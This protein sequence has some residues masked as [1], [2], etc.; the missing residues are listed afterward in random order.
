M[1]TGPLKNKI[2]RF[3]LARLQGLQ[4]RWDRLSHDPALWHQD[5]EQL[6]RWRTTYRRLQALTRWGLREQREQLRET[7]HGKGLR[8]LMKASSGIRDRHIALEYLAAWADSAP[9]DL[10]PLDRALR[11]EIE[12]HIDRWCDQWL[13]VLQSGPLTPWL[14]PE[15]KTLKKPNSALVARLRKD[16]NK[17]WNKQANVLAEIRTRPPNEW[18]P[19]E[20]HRARI[21]AK[22]LRYLGE[23]WR[24]YLNARQRNRL[25]RLRNIHKIA[26]N[27]QDGITLA[28]LMQPWMQ[29]NGTLEPITAA[30]TWVHARALGW[31]HEQSLCLAQALD[32]LDA[33]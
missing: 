24:K 21:Q 29:P 30:A 10:T 7:L 9:L 1:D 4:S 19:A 33:V 22:H 31:H 12:H 11:V 23:W 18:D 3:W 25:E 6:H 5:F 13:L 20:V 16:F 8:D 17:R 32:R 2:H 27:M 28:A 26:G 15:P 14:E